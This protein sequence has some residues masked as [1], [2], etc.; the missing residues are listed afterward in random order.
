MPGAVLRWLLMVAGLIAADILLGREVRFDPLY[1]ALLAW[2]AW[3]AGWRAGLAG[4]VLVA[5]GAILKA[6]LLPPLHAQL[7]LTALDIA[8][9]GAV[10]SLLVAA[11]SRWRAALDRESENARTD[12]LTGLANRRGFQEALDRDLIRQQ[13]SRR[14]LGLAL[15]DIDGV[16]EVNDSEGHSA[17]D[18]LMQEVA[19]ALSATI[20]RTDSCGRL[21]GT[22][23]AASLPDCDES[24]AESVIGKL[25]AALS[26]VLGD[27]PQPVS[28]AVGF[29]IATASSAERDHLLDAAAEALQVARMPG[30]GGMH[31][32]AYPPS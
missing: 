29:V 20:R 31:L 21:H 13:R 19:H 1:A 3:H 7:W 22:M 11:V 25:E 14:P 16:R 4:V 5:L 2:M 23:F 27:R 24:A 6:A 8:G 28:H 18:E 30:S 12:T 32:T 9:A 17:G 10:Q 26:R 15:I